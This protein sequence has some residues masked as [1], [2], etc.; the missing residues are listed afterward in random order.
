MP[1]HA[2]TASLI[3]TPAGPRM[4]ASELGGSV[5]ANLRAALHAVQGGLC[6]MCGQAT[7]LDA[8]SSE[9]DCAEV[10][11]IVPGCGGSKTGVTEGNVFIGCRRCNVTSATTVTNGDLRPYLVRFLRVDLIPATFPRGWRNTLAANTNSDAHATQSD[12]ACASIFA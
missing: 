3:T 2:H 9:S 5:K 12:T 10:S 4:C 7:R 1:T 11:H 8:L 6:A